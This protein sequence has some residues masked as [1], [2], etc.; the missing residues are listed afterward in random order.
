M[1]FTSVKQKRTYPFYMVQ[2]FFICVL[3][4]IYITSIKN[5]LM[6]FTSVKQKRTYPFCAHLKNIHGSTLTQFKKSKST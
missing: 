5:A 4:L 6:Y 3:I 1:Y 2:L